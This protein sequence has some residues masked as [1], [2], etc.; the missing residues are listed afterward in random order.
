MA[1]K[2][3]SE[4]LVVGAGPIGLFAALCLAERGRSVQVI[5]KEWHGA[6]HSYALALHPGTLRLLQEHDVAEELLAEGHRV[7]RVAFYEGDRRAGVLDVAALGGP[8]PFVLV[9][10]QSALEK[11]FENRLK[12]HKVKVFWNHQCLAMSQ[13]EGGVNA[14]VARMEKYSMGYPIAHTEWMVA[15]EYDVQSRF[16][17]GADGYH[18]SVRKNLGARYE[19][20]GEAEAF[21]VYE[22]P[23]KIGFQ[24][25]VRVVF[26]EDRLNVIWPLNPQRGRWSFQVDK[27]RPAPP[28]IDGLAEMI[29][30]RAPWFDT[31]VEELHWTA[32][33]VFERRLVDRFGRDR[34]WLAGDAAH[35]TGPVGVQSMNVGIR[36]AHDLAERF[37]AVLDNGA[38]LETLEALE[39]ERQTEWN[40]LLGGAG[41][42]RVTDR[43]PDWVRSHAE[44]IVPCVPCSGPDLAKVLEQ[45]GL[46]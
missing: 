5:D 22:F 11:A 20:R 38:P 17:I 16:L 14:R 19:H 8:Y 13:I 40:G 35:I 1:L 46:E 10:P 28:T 24:H 29:R 45:I 2:H 18:S 43:A 30:T 15:R 31:R 9:V 44:R 27:D 7:D 23:S 33:V 4:V 39:S 3:E 37:A 32:T 42:P 41:A 26:H 36:E 34:V 12:Q 6:S 25:E 21:S